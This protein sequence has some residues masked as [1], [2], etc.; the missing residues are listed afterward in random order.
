MK[1]LLL[2]SFLFLSFIGLVNA[3][4][5]SRPIPYAAAVSPY[6]LYVGYHTTTVL[7]FPVAVVDGDRGFSEIIVQKQKNVQNVL[8]VK[9]A[10]KGFQPTNLHVYTSDGKIYPFVVEYCE[11]PQTV[12]IDCA[13]LTN[14]QVATSVEVEKIE[15]TE[16]QFREL[17]DS[18]KE[19]EPFVSAKTSRY[20]MDLELNTIHSINDL[21]LFGFAIENQSGLD[22][23]RDYTRLIIRDKQKIKRSSVQEQEIIPVY[24]DQ[25]NLVPG[26]SK[27][28]FVIAVPKFTIPDRKEFII[29]T[30]EKNGGRHLSLKVKN[31]Q[32]LKAR[33]F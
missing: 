15:L 12:T 11:F 28:Q 2:C 9:A 22:F 17:A 10:K 18:A 14:E 6:K 7:M 27:G 23:S 20:G 30:T 4:T 26:D 5:A 3:Q 19:T 31:K 32:L 16:K 25:M 24:T 13:K 1:K 8:N 21:L 29:Q 33:K